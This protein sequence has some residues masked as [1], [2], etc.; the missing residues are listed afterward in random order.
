MFDVFVPGWWNFLGRTGMCGFV[1][2]GMSLRVGFEVPKA[3]SILDCALSLPSESSSDIP[4][5][6]CFSAIPACMLLC[7]LT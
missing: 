1:D 4:L 3:H 7:C 6:Y 2:R 5:S